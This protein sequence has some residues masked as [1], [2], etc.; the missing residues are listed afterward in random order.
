MFSF[1]SAEVDNVESSPPRSSPPPPP[2]LRKV[3][4]MQLRADEEKDRSVLL[5][6]GPVTN[7]VPTQSDSE[8]SSSSGDS[9][10]PNWTKR[11]KVPRMRMYADEEEV[12][13]ERRKA[14]VQAHT[15]REP[16]HF[17]ER[18]SRSVERET[19]HRRRRRSSSVHRE[20]SRSHRSRERK[21]RKSET[22]ERHERDERDSVSRNRDDLRSRLHKEGKSRLKGSVSVITSTVWDRLNDHQP[23]SAAADWEQET[24]ESESEQGDP[25]ADDDDG[26]YPDLRNSLFQ[27]KNSSPTLD[28]GDL[29]SKLNLKKTM[30][31]V[32]VQKSP[33]RIEIDNDEYYRLIGSDQE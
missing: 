11:S 9:D 24:S 17:R 10:E 32:P 30:K 19:R 23:D 26:D 27:S 7:P 28:R 33:L 2:P 3:P 20:S 4:T 18:E 12:R 1:C 31:Q 25:V 15:R 16:R 21:Q 29:R 22:H 14:Q 5:R 6:I 13:I 8:D